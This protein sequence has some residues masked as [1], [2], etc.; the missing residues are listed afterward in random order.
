MTG[1]W[2]ILND[3]RKG[4][5]SY[6]DLYQLL[7]SDTLTPSSLVWKAGMK[8]WQTAAKVDDLVAMFDSLPP[9]VPKISQ[10]KRTWP[11][12]GRRH[13]G[14][15]IA[16][17]IGGCG[18]VGGLAAAAKGQL[19]TL[20][21]ATVMILGAL[22]YRSAKKRKLG[23]VRSTITRL[24]LEFTLLL[25]IALIILLQNN[26]KQ[27]IATDPVPNGVIPLWAILAY[28]I[29][30]ALPKSLMRAQGQ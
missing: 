1:W 16:L 18:L 21:A 14:S 10:S 22:A 17:G 20:I 4:P 3:E 25:L 28:L 12:E 19:G 11:W 23:E 13:L 8:E 2:Y 24:I 15:T 5:V 9:Q 26:L 27:L 6:D 7:I 30:V 29:I